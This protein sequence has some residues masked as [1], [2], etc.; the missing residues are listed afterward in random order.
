MFRMNLFVTLLAVLA[1]C[2]GMAQTD[3]P[4]VPLQTLGNPTSDV[5]ILSVFY[6]HHENDRF[7]YAVAGL[8][9]LNGDG[10]A[11]FSISAEFER[12]VYVY[13]GGTTIDTVP[14]LTFSSNDIT[15]EMR[16]GDWNGDGALDLVTADVNY[17]RERGRVYIYWGGADLDTIPDVVLEAPPSCERYF[18]WSLA[19]GDI[20][21]DGIDDLLV[22]GENH[23]GGPASIYVYYGARDFPTEP[24][25]V[26]AG[27]V[28][29]FNRVRSGGDWN[30]DGYDDVVVTVVPFRSAIYLGGDPPAPTPAFVVW[31]GPSV[32]LSP[33]WAIGDV[34]GDGYDDLCHAYFGVLLGGPEPDT[35]ADMLFQP[36]QWRG[37]AVSGHF[38]RDRWA[39]V[40]I[41]TPAYASWTGAIWFYPGGNPMNPR[42]QWA[43]SGSGYGAFGDPIEN[44]GD[45]DGNGV[46]DFLV[47]EPSYPFLRDRGRVFLLPTD[48]THI[49]RVGAAGGGGFPALAK[50]FPPYPNPFNSRLVVRY[51]LA[52]RAWV[53]LWVSD[54]LG[55]EVAGLVEGWKTTGSHRVVWQGRDAAGRPVP[56]G[57]YLVRLVADGKQRVQKVLLVR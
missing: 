10:Y 41:G 29:D 46:E 50:L 13:F 4:A 7:G 49:A 44:A 28:G 18:G 36:R 8:G 37:V 26:W 35:L 55:R 11:D 16:S 43:V 57:V 9:D 32:A 20:N 56:S 2:A 34:N 24:S 3:S 5:H 14:D 6:G 52:R 19:T 31:S 39:D 17:N 21:G 12:K 30:G 48:T 38:N 33:E 45:V 1:A 53:K 54:V 47:A 42:Y 51:T 27:S 23:L 22:N 25:F 15:W 40:L